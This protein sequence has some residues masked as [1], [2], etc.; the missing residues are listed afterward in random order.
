MSLASLGKELSLEVDAV[1]KL[2]VDM[3]IDEKM[4]G[5]VDQ[6]A[7]VV[8]RSDVRGGGSKEKLILRYATLQKDISEKFHSR[9]A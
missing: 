7:G 3:I 1:E 5:T 9:N 8:T 2:V 4:S 6:I